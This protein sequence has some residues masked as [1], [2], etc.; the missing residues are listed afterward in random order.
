MVSTPASP[1]TAA[2]GVA[3]LWAFVLALASTLTLHSQQAPLKNVDVIQM[4]KANLGAEVV[5]AKIEAS[6]TQF[7][8]STDALAVLKAAGVADAIITAMIKAVP[9][10]RAAS[11]DTTEAS[12]TAN[13][14]KATVYVYRP[15]KFMGKALEPSVFLDEQ[16]ILDMDNG[17]YFT[18]HLDAGRHILRSNEKNSEIDQT[19]DAGK[20]YY[21]K[22]TIATGMMKG[23][24]QLAMVTEKLADKEMNKLRP[25][26]TDNIEDAYKAIVDVRP[27]DVRPIK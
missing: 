22:M 27:I 5:V 23:H 12:A 3:I 25:L 6:S 1:F 26:D 17:R 11:T 10:K 20:I 4:V 8:T 21:V 7:D 24:G 13:E 14:S 9:A 16:K 15:G 2:R 18:L 19:W